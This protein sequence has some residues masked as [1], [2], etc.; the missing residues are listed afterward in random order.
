M[1]K[2]YWR[3]AVSEAKAGQGSEETAVVDA[4]PA[5]AGSSDA[6]S[7]AVPAPAPKSSQPLA[8][9][10]SPK[11]APEQDAAARADAL[12]VDT[13]IA[14]AQHTEASE[15]EAPRDPDHVRTMP[16]VDRRERRF[17]AIAAALVLAAVAGAIG[18]VSAT[19]GFP[20]FL[21][22]DATSARLPSLEAWAA[23]I[24]ADILVL[25]ASAEHNARTSVAQYSKASDRLDKIEKAQAE[26]G[27]KV[28]KLSEAVEKLRAAQLTA[29]PSGAAEVTGSIGPVAAA[30]ATDPK[31]ADP[32]S[33]VARLPTLQGWLL[34]EVGN[35]AALIE[36]RHGIYEVSAGAAVPGLGRIDAIR[37]QDG[38][39]VVVTA[40]GLIAR[41]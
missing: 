30:P 9:V 24:D 1:V 5:I 7:Q 16:P 29:T 40:K 17:G 34:L 41:R 13:T 2:L 12:K 18:G 33:A 4:K 20:H 22:D 36:G 8:S 15:A 31:P 23:R 27:A 26:P 10:E 14:D 21:G 19:M 38:R 37:R 28:A 35:G 25:K 6:R 3:L 11:L 39:W 32:K